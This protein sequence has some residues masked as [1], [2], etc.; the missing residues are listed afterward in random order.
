VTAKSSSVL[1]SGRI[2]VALLFAVFGYMKLVNFNG[3]V[4]AFAQL[5][6]PLPHLAVAL[7]VSFE[8][9]CGLLLI[10]GWKTRQA[11]WLLAAFTVAATLI[12]HRFWSAEAAQAFVQT[13]NFY[14]NASIVGGLLALAVAGPGRYSLDRG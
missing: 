8:L 9:G 2:L 3:S 10:V 14:Q 1:L 4:E 5:G 12:A 7:A 6:L 11:A 13:Q